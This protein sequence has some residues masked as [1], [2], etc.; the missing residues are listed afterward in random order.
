MLLWRLTDLEERRSGVAVVTAGRDVLGPRA[1]AWE[2]RAVELR[3]TGGGTQVPG[4]RGAALGTGIQREWDLGK[5]TVWGVTTHHPPGPAQKPLSRG[6]VVEVRV[7]DHLWVRQRVTPSTK[8]MIEKGHVEGEGPQR[9]VGGVVW[10]TRGD[11]GLPR[12]ERGQ[13]CRMEGPL[14]GGGGGAQ[15]ET[16]LSGPGFGPWMSSADCLGCG[17]VRGIRCMRG[18]SWKHSPF[19]HRAV[20]IRRK[21][22]KMGGRQ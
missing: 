15:L 21:G 3:L 9:S 2:T 6:Q 8:G 4:Q 17:E 5:G 18:L 14:G 1:R 20:G 16:S 22:L 19:V 10:K 7:W 13:C 12:G 11:G